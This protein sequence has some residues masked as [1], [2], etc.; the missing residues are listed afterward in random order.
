NRAAHPCR[1]QKSNWASSPG[2][3]WI[4]TD[5]AFAALNLG[6]RLSRTARTTV[7]YEPSKPSAL[8]L[9]WTEIDNSRGCASSIVS[10]LVRQCS[11]ITVA[12]VGRADGGGP[13]LRCRLTVVRC[14][15]VSAA[16]SLIV[17]PCLCR[18]LI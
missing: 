4:G 6:P 7:G 17:H 8:S 10:I 14:Q 16:I 12:S 9:L 11:V 13:F 3:V 18:S 2:A 5:T 1:S 15:P